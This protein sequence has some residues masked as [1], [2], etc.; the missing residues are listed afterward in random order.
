MLPEAFSIMLSLNGSFVQFGFAL[1]AGAGGMP[2]ASHPPWQLGWIG[3]VS[4]AIAT[5][6]VIFGLLSS[7]PEVEQEY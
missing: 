3:A 4:A 5:G 2:A 1:G 7:L 6:D